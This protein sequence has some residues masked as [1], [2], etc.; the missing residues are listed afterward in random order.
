LGL[1]FYNSFLILYKAGIHIASLFDGKAK[2]WVHGRKEIWD[3]LKKQVESLHAD[4]A[5]DK[6]Q[7]EGRES[8]SKLVWIHCASLGEFEQGRPVIERLRSQY[9]NCKLLLTFFSPSGYEIRKNYTSVD[10]VSYLP[11]D[12]PQNAPR[13]LKIV[14]PSLVIF[15]KYEYWYYYLKEINQKKI[16][17][18]LVSA[19]F[20]E[21]AV[22]FKWYGRLQRKM[23]SF[24]TRI[25]VQNPESRKLLE[26][27]GLDGKCSV[28]GDTRF[29]RVIEIAEN[30][31]PLL[32]IEEFMANGKSIIAGSTWPE[33][34]EI[35]Q[36]TILAINDPSL[37][38]IVAPHE[39]T[40]H[41]ISKLIKQFPGAV[42]YSEF[43]TSGFW[44]QKPG[45]LV[46]DNI[47]MLSRLYK[48]AYITYVGGGFG[49][50]IHNTLEAA[51]FGK[52]VL[53]GPAYEKFN[54]AIDL[55][56]NGG[57]V[58]ISNS[59]ECSTVIQEFLHDEAEYSNSCRH[60]KE[61]VYARRGATQ[62]IMQFLQENRLL[63]N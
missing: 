6:P 58:S 32:G 18:L 26:Q 50:G 54:E 20:R 38:L 40:N 24:F 9:P 57:A 3:R 4:A 33:D 51:V 39:I 28:A 22:F 15:V 2:K 12:G 27:I 5:G 48:Y 42:L 60:S 52:P 11:I 55:V 8:Q 16:P 21:N 36:K 25:F 61:Y 49:K 1:F 29:D 34:E 56:A 37:K 30:A 59:R 45:I 7:T 13:F 17:L 63:T 35:L 10:L 44:S 53:F 43:K 41:H 47:G 31:S 23:L 14:K 62:I 46:I 19:L